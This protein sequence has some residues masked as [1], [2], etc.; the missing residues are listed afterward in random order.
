MTQALTADT[1]GS[2]LL[3]IAIGGL[4]SGILTPLAPLLVDKL[5]GAPGM[6]RLALVAVPFA[7]LVFVV[8][9]RCSANPVWAALVAGHRHHD[10]LCLCGECRRVHRRAGR[11]RQPRR[12]A[13]SWPVL[14]AGWSARR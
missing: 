1:S 9:R 14:P 7:V 2:D 13:I 3:K 5:T 12:C 6:L 8:V 11:R 4:V 10:R